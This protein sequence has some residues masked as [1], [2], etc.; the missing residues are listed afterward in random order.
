MTTTSPTKTAVPGPAPAPLPAEPGKGRNRFKIGAGQQLKGGPLTYVFLIIVGLGSVFPLYW[1]LVAASHDQQRVLDTPPPFIPG[2]RLFSNLQTAWE[3][4][5]LGKAIVNTAIVAGCI[6]A[7]TLFFC[8]LAGYAFAKMRF[9]GRNVLMTAVIATLTVPP[10]LSVVPLFMMMSDI[11]WNGQLESVI[12][13]TLVGAFGVFFMRQYLIEA[14]PYELIEAA[15]VDGASNIR[16]VWNV[17]LPAAR[18]A[19]M[20]LGMLTFVQ[21]WN[22][23]FWPF[24]ALNQENPTIQVALGLLS[25]S[26]TPDQSIVMAGALISTLPLLLVF[27]VFGKQIVGGIMAGAVKG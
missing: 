22:D 19:M 23:F 7:A 5:N 10:Q 11:G 4:A 2:G 6:T 15:K 12:F 1:T 18:P 8:T 27:I 26:Y 16:I 21:A 9:R 13:P 17:V 14:L 20:V 3:Q 25:A 24:L